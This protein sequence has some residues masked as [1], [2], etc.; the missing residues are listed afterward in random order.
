MRS[1]MDSEIPVI[2]AVAAVIAVGGIAGFLLLGNGSGVPR[3]RRRQ[4]EEYGYGLYSS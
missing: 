2:A 3:A 1:A 4:W